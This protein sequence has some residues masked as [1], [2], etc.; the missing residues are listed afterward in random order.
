MQRR[1]V[2]AVIGAA[3]PSKQGYEQARHVGRLIARNDTVLLCGGLG[4]IMEAA[5]RGCAEEG[6]MTVGVL[7]GPEA[8]EANPFIHIALPTNMGHARNVI[9]AHS[10]DALIAVEGE[11]GTLSEIAVSLKLGRRVIS[12]GCRWSVEGVVMADSPEQA[13][14]LAFK[15]MIGH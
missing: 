4:G 14:E 7:P 11:Y 2:I 15:G 3:Q 5:A 8:R 1:P 12:L 10:A 13:L 6:G 9:I